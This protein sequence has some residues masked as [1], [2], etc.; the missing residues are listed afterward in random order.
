MR[1]LITRSQDIRS[2][3]LASRSLLPLLAVIFLGG[4][5]ATVNRTADDAA[6]IS[7]SPDA[8]KHIVLTLSGTN[9]TESSPDWNAFTE[10][11]QTSM[12]EAASAAGASFNLASGADPLPTG[13]ATLVKIKVNDF[14][15]VSQ[16]KRYAIGVLSGNAYMDLDV[17]FVE[18]PSNKNLGT[19]KYSTS[20]SAWHGVFSAM[21]PKQV[22]AVA[23]NIVKEV[24]QK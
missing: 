20:S 19:R 18:T 7:S 24:T 1:F 21:T 10:A 16:A 12:T 2:M 14:R 22:E 23:Q 13:V 4:C 9:G 11:W 15:Y 8:A 6:R 17:E 5:A 3:S